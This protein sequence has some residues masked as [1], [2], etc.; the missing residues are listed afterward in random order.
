LSLKGGTVGSGLSAGFHLSDMGESGKIR[1][2]KAAHVVDATGKL[3]I[4]GLWTCT[5]IFVAARL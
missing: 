5:Y 4:P 3:L 2:P 1:A